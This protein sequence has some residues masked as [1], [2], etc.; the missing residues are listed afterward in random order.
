MPKEP[1]GKAR[2][3]W[4]VEQGRLKQRTRATRQW[5][6]A[7]DLGR[8][9]PSLMQWAV[10]LWLL[11]RGQHVKKR[12]ESVALPCRNPV[13]LPFLA[14]PGRDKMCLLPQTYAPP[15]PCPMHAT[16]HPF[17]AKERCS[18]ALAARARATVFPALSPHPARACPTSTIW[19]AA[20]ACRSPHPYSW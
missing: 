8:T 10:D 17:W 2:D 5:D 4:L 14:M 9:V 13:N 15:P 1:D 7:V 6:K 19:D 18:Q 20:P 11:S 3:T 16:Q 12:V